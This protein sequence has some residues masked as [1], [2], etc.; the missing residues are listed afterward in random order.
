[1][2]PKLIAFCLQAISFSLHRMLSSVVCAAVSPAVRGIRLCLY[3]S[4]FY[5]YLPR[6]WE[7]HIS[8]SGGTLLNKY[9]LM[10]SAIK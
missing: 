1:M 9:L 7:I 6:G 10:T 2:Q 3:C 8:R 4:K 5:L